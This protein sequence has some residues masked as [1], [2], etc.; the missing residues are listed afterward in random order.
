MYSITFPF[1]YR[2]RKIT[3]IFFF[4]FAFIS[5]YFAFGHLLQNVTG[6]KMLLNES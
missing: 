5:H 2:A 6:V 4:F 3:T 1:H